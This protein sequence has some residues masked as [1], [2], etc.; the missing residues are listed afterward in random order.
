MAITIPSTGTASVALG[1]TLSLVAAVTGT[2]NTA[3][4]WTVNT[5]TDGNS[6]FGT[7]AGTGLAVTYNAP[8]AIPGANNPVTITAISQADDAQ[9]ASITVTITPSTSSP[10]EINVP[11][12]S[13]V[14]GI[15]LNPNTLT[16]TLG[17]VD[18]GS[19][20]GALAPSVHLTC[21]SAGVAPVTLTQGSST[22]LWLLGR[23]LTSGDGS[24]I[25][26]LTVAVSGM[27]G[28]VTVGQMIPLL[29]SNNSAGLTNIAFQVTVSASAT[30]GPRN[31]IVT[32]PNTKELETFV[33]AI[34][35]QTP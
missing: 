1:K 20:T 28:D 17:L 14:T 33:G 16:P 31:I 9:S 11:G 23:G 29:T 22:I 7:I 12:N 35:I 32:N 25:S 3:V 5:V 6:T 19:C 8:G 27:S 24:A 18:I 13:D 2:A 15:D 26:G 21:P 10:N 4:T 30:A 34:Q